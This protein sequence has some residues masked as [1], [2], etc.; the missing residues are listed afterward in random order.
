MN[1][2]PARAMTPSKDNGE[3]IEMIQE[4]KKREE[5]LTVEL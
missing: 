1:K 5:Q 2:S 3:E 4:F